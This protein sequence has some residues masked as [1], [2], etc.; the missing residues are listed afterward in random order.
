LDGTGIGIAVLDSGIDPD[1]QAFA[2]ATGSRI[3]VNQDFT[4][5]N[6]TDDPYGHGTHVASIA[7]G[8]GLISSGKYRG[9]APNA[10]LINLRVLNS[11]GIGSTSGVLAALDWIMSNRA[12][13]NIRVVNMSLGMPAVESFEDDPLCLAVRD[14]VNSARCTTALPFAETHFQ[15]L[16]K[17]FQSVNTSDKD[18]SYAAIL[19]FR[20]YLEPELGSFRLGDPQPQHF[21]VA[22]HRDP[23]RQIDRFVLDVPVISH[24][25]LDRVQIHDRVN[26]VELPVL[27][28]LHLINHFIRHARDQ[29]RR[30]FYVVNLFEVLLDLSR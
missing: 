20:H 6:R 22:L 18:V 25:E 16:P 19:Q 7:A 21:F 4:G 23:N 14:L 26:L 30:D 11:D 2:G 1:H 27:P 15:S 29:A 28:R 17:A 13:Y 5:E 9:V 8:N 10:N 12:A 3:I 24:F